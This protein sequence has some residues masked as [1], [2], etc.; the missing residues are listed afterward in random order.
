MSSWFLPR[1]HSLATGIKNLVLEYDH[2]SCGA[3]GVRADEKFS[4]LEDEQT[5]LFSKPA[6]K[7][8]TGFPSI[9]R[10]LSRIPPTNS[11]PKRHRQG[12]GGG[13]TPAALLEKRLGHESHPPSASQRG[14]L[15]LH[16][17]QEIYVLSMTQE[18]GFQRNIATS[19]KNPLAPALT[20]QG[21][22]ERGFAT[23]H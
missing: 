5:K 15:F 7:R 10:L 8:N 20:L 1:F 2:R 13:T 18:H 4:V 12:G 9:W 21:A 3:W 6:N 22:S 16:I 17:S 19:E 23:H 11:Q 14:L